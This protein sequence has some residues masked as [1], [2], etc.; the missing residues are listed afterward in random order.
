MAELVIPNINKF[1]L[2][3]DFIKQVVEEIETGDNLTRK[4]YA[5]DS[6]QVRTGRLKEYVQRRLVEMYP[7]THTMYTVADYSVLKKVTDKLAKS[8]KEAPIRKIAGDKNKNA[9]EIFTKLTDKYRLNQAMKDFDV[10]Y[11]QHK[12]ALL[13]CFMD[14]EPMAT[15]AQ[16]M[17]NFKFFALAPYEY[18]VIKDADGKVRVVILSYP[19]QSLTGGS[20]DGYDSL[21]AETGMSDEAL[22]ERRYTFWTDTEYAEATVSGKKGDGTDKTIQVSYPTQGG[23]NPYGILP[24]V[25]APM[26][27]SVNYPNNNPLPEQTVE[28]NALFSVY[29]TSA[30]MQV[31]ILKITRPESQKLSIA[32]Q[33]M[34]TAIEVPQSDRPEDKPSD[35]EFI[36]PTPNM[37]G[38]KDAIVT[39]LTTIL[40]EQGITGNSVINPNESFTSGLDRLIASADVQHI[41]EDNQ[42]L[43]QKVEQQIYRIVKRQLASQSQDVLPE[44]GFQI[45]YRKPK[46]M[47]SDKEKLEN[48]KLMKELNLWADYELIQAYD[49]NLSADEAKAKL[50]EIEK[51]RA[52]RRA[53]NAKQG[54]DEQG[55][56]L[57]TPPENKFG[58][59]KEEEKEQVKK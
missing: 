1:Q 30:N 59:K 6:D 36:A 24:F 50:A 41:I 28:F 17:L 31:G 15:A 46:V 2:N 16:P 10:I 45:I 25:Y 4:R 52:Q 8:Y 5:W 47:I 32:S 40:D 29:L 51:E 26:D 49:P 20:G 58:D 11:T 27:Y 34:Y 55:K 42:E 7:K 14:R 38:H 37:D 23:A 12:Y 56:P 39:Y 48:L 22:K 19:P 18:D 13:A 44:E 9:S 3:P 57:P 43:Y 35:I 54:L 33:S 21:I 53:E